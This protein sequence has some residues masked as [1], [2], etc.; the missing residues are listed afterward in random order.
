MKIGATGLA[1]TEL[2]QQLCA[3]GFVCDV[4]GWFDAETKAA[5]IE[6]QKASGL[7]PYGVVGP[8]TKSCLSGKRDP[9]WLSVGAIER[10]AETLDVPVAALLAV[11]DVESGGTGFTDGKISLLF[12]RHKFYQSIESES[13]GRAKELHQMMPGICNP[14]RGGYSGGAAEYVRFATA[15]E[16]APDHAICATSFGMFQVMG[17]QWQLVNCKSPDDFYQQMLSGEDAQLDIL[18]RFIQSQAGIHKAL[19][20]RKWADF[21]RLYNGSAY[22]EN[23]YDH[24]LQVAFEQFKEVYPCE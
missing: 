2:Q 12:E 8:R 18:V 10:A 1:V 13:P 22:R 14:Q 11:I 21:A 24:K 5:V 16:V 3:R 20:A 19:K 4:D 15:Y 17:F 7:V 9:L 23:Q 6:F